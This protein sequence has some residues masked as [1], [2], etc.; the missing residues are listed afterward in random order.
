MSAVCSCATLHLTSWQM[1][2]DV[3]A[4]CAEPAPVCICALTCSEDACSMQCQPL[5]SPA[6]S[7]PQP[8]V[9]GCPSHPS[10]PRLTT[11]QRKRAVSRCRGALAGSR[12]LR[13]PWRRPSK[14]LKQPAPRGAKDYQVSLPGGNCCFTSPC[15]QP[16]GRQ[17]IYQPS[18]LLE[19]PLSGNC[20]EPMGPK[21]DRRIGI[22]VS[23]AC[24]SCVTTW[25]IPVSRAC[26][27]CVTT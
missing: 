7:V 18:G 8:C 23:R 25:C 5:C 17:L 14:L 27:S 13:L 16:L 19:G 3:P 4:R 20:L 22:P 12:T 1:P 24:C 2:S 15:T 11:S 26:C 9:H 6:R 10:S 21:G